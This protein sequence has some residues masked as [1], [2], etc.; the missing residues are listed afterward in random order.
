MIQRNISVPA[1]W[2][3]THLET[4][5]SFPP[6]KYSKCA[7]QPEGHDLSLLHGDSNWTRA[8]WSMTI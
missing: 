5:E 6:Q 8:R 7:Q 4:I 3:K 2:L 1:I